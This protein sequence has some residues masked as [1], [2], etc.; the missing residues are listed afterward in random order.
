MSQVRDAGAR[1]RRDRSL[2]TAQ[3]ARRD[4][5]DRRG[6]GGRRPRR[7]ASSPLVCVGEPWSVRAAGRAD[8]HVADQ[9]RSA[10]V[11]RRPGRRR[12]ASSSRTSRSGRSATAVAPPTPTDVVGV[13]DRDP[14]GRRR[15]G[16]RRPAPRPPLRRQRQPR[17]TPRRCWSSTLDGLVRRTRR[18]DRRRLHR[19]AAICS[20]CAARAPSR[21]TATEPAA[22]T[23]PHQPAGAVDGHGPDRHLAPPALAARIVGVVALVV[24]VVAMA[25]STKFLTPA[26]LATIAPKPFDPAATA[27]DLYSRAQTELPGK[28]ADLGEVV[29]A[30]PVGPQERGRHLQGRRRRARTPTSSR[31]RRPARVVEATDASLRLQVD[32]VPEPDAGARPADHRRERQRRCATRWASSSPTPPARRTTS[33]WPTSSRS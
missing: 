10:L 21:P 17:A 24:L 18:V 12:A 9:V 30:L 16:A 11:R 13:L 20:R 7:R 26:E 8:A 33:T 14:R 2:R 19:A 28:A 6:Q 29:P 1:D 22:P 15:P 23:A 4:R 31:S 3:P 5:R 27:E 32:G 25:L